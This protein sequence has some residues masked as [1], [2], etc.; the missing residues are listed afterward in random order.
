MS[1][2][3]PSNDYPNALPA[4]TQIR[5]YTII[6]VIGIGGFSIVYKAMDTALMREV[7]IKEYFPGGIS[8]RDN[9]GTVRSQ[10]RETDA[11]RK[12]I[13]SFLNEGKLLAQFDHPALVRVY[14][15][16]EER[17]TAYLAMRLYSG[18]TLRDAVN[19]G[20]WSANEQTLPALLLPVCDALEVLHAA[21]C[22]H[23]D[24]APDNILLGENNW[25][26]LLDFGAARKAIEGTQVFTA[27]LKPGYAPIEQYG[28]GELK[29]GPWTDIYALAGVLYF[30]LS[31][32]PPPTAIS[33]MLRD[34]MP[35]PR[36]VFAGRLPERWLDAMALSLAVKPE[37]RPQSI[38]EFISLMGWD[39]MSTPVVDLVTQ[40]VRADLPPPGLV[41]SVMLVQPVAAT[42]PVDSVSEATR[43]IDSKRYV[44]ARGDERLPETTP[45]P[46]PTPTPTP[47]PA[48][49]PPPLAPL[50]PMERVAE[51]T[52]ASSSVQPGVH[53]AAAFNHGKWIAIVAGLLSAAL[54]A[55]W[56]M[57]GS[58]RNGDAT[59]AHA[60]TPTEISPKSAPPVAHTADPVIVLPP[61][62]TAG[63]PN[64][65]LPKGAV[66]TETSAVKTPIEPAKPTIALTP[67]R[68]IAPRTTVRPPR[69]EGEPRDSR[70]PGRC[71]GLLDRWG[72]GAALSDEEQSFLT[73]KCK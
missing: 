20:S 36:D 56:S 60:P 11:F 21:R 69:A 53:D 18:V 38:G 32:G 68:K 58:R 25:P 63:P 54:F 49:P 37:D 50:A 39:A 51:T 44:T 45:K 70:Q 27:I 28:D 30:T 40:E 35:R 65:S 67:E 22:Y 57:S 17:G 10:P 48:P 9:D 42:A 8:L 29:Q 19:G 59:P 12:G 13:E 41:E 46:T 3:A 55:W 1:S 26:V 31:G 73:E 7:A 61:N 5:D 71:A 24:V 4:G 47:T 14:R 33:R 43:I 6:S 64:T 66:A 52:T 72:L 15:F 23:R 2:D 62:D 16:W 34:S